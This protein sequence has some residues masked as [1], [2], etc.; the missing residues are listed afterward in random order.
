V[1]SSHL[2]DKAVD[3]C[4]VP[5]VAADMLEAMFVASLNALLDIGDDQELHPG[6]EGEPATVIVLAWERRQLRDAALIGDP[7]FQL[8]LERLLA[9]TGRRPATD[10]SFAARRIRQLD[11]VN[12]FEAWAAQEMTGRT[13]ASRAEASKLNRLLETWFSAIQVLVNSTTVEIQVTHRLPAGQA[14]GPRT[15][16]VS[17][18][19]ADWTRVAC[20]VGRQRLRHS[21]WDDAEI[22]GA[23]QA[24]TESNGRSPTWVDWVHAG[25]ARPNSLTVQ[26]HFGRWDRAL[27]RAGLARYV[28]AVPPRNRAWSDAEVIQALSDWAREHGRPPM[29]HE[30]LRAAPGR[31]CNVTVSEHFGTW[32]A[33]LATAGFS[34]NG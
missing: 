19:R 1:C 32:K 4:D 29:W 27:R 25:P 14:S 21:S 5:P 11:A 13:V 9:R 7:A 17:L 20:H 23:L 26:R 18:D 30:W 10:A 6:A 8:A 12:R 22:L 28:P 15:S 3:R 34:S 24:W 33:G 31:P 2:K 16:V